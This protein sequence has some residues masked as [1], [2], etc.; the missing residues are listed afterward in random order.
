[1]PSPGSSWTCLNL[2]T[3]VVV[4]ARSMVL[5]GVTPKL[6][7]LAHFTLASQ[8]PACRR[9]PVQQP[10]VRIVRR[11][12]CGPRGRPPGRRLRTRG[13]PP[14]PARSGTGVTV[15]ESASRKGGSSPMCAS[16]TLTIPGRPAYTS[17]VETPHVP[18]RM[19]VPAQPRALPLPSERLAAHA[20]VIRLPTPQLMDLLE[21]APSAPFAASPPSSSSL[22]GD[23]SKPDRFIRAAKPDRLCA[24]TSGIA[25]DESR[26]QP[27]SPRT[28]G[29]DRVLRR[30]SGRG[31]G[32][33]GRLWPTAPA[34]ARS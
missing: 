16:A 20:C 17:V 6:N 8:L 5:H 32:D 24:P 30:E 4:L 7:C 23:R 28:T 34:P 19:A 25:L 15:E 12:A 18:P 29:S 21:T 11:R 31:S 13:P 1:M 27:I 10:L 2:N 22:F 14:W 26:N 9:P 3:I 33:D